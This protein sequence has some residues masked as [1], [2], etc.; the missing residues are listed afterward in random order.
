LIP[1][2][3]SSIWTSGSHLLALGHLKQAYCKFY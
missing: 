1:E 2:L 3:F